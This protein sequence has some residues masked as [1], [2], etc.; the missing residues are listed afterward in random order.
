MKHRD[1]AILAV[2]AVA[3]TLLALF[4]PWQTGPKR[5]PGDLL[6][7]EITAL[8]SVSLDVGGAHYQASKNNTGTWDC[9]APLPGGVDSG[10]LRRMH[11]TLRLLRTIRSVPRSEEHRLENRGQ[12]VVTLV[13]PSQT[14]TLELGAVTADGS[15]QWVA[16]DH[17]PDAQL[18][19]A[20]L[21]VELVASI[22]SLRNPQL[23]PWQVDRTQLLRIT[24]P[25]GWI[26]LE[27]DAVRWGSGKGG[28]GDDDEH[29]VLADPA[30]VKGLL[31]ILSELVESAPQGC[32]SPPQ[33]SIAQGENIVMLSEEL[34]VSPKPLATLLALL[35]APVS[36]ARM[37]LFASR[38]PTTDFSIHCGA[39]EQEVRIADV[40]QAALRRWWRILD[41][42]PQRL[43]ATEPHKN[44]C[45]I[46]GEDW[47]VAVGLRSVH[48]TQADVELVATSP[49]PGQLFVLDPKARQSFQNLATAFKSTLLIE[50]DA[51]FVRWLE[52]VD[53][54]VK[55]RWR[56]GGQAGSWRDKDE[57]LVRDAQAARLSAMATTLATLEAE[58]FVQSNGAKRG[59]RTRRIRAYFDAAIGE[60]ETLH[61]I[62]LW[63]DS[64]ACTVSVGEGPEAVLRAED[65]GTLWSSHSP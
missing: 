9:L 15:K 37:Q 54:A 30:Q 51:V 34:C 55:R 3:T 1:L 48:D 44:L 49:H 5:P 63:G 23:V 52:V 61:E 58:R 33:I 12:A 36:L 19:E 27:G 13:F 25:R 35:Q 65:C 39:S 41:E 29:E 26:E 62:R 10:A 47:T 56:P 57:L 16:I 45:T 7:N 4:D 2:L 38:Q 20:H 32:V 43:V 53:G 31:Q 59:G 40:D 46:T 8:E 17:G 22:K 18:V 28:R 6:G 50:E 42:A 21:L 14:R 11:A 60:K 64:S 24:S